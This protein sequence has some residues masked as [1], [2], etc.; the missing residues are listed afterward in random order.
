M[1]RVNLTSAVNEFC[2]CTQINI[3]GCTY[4]IMGIMALSYMGVLTATYYVSRQDKPELMLLCY[5]T[6][7]KA[8]GMSGDL[9]DLRFMADVQNYGM[10]MV[11][12]YNDEIMKI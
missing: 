2:R 6:Q 8:L 3:G 11:E 9:A 12:V 10:K 1:K 4:T 5:H 7:G